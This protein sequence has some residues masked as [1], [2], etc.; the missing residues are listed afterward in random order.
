MWHVDTV[1]TYI[2][3]DYVMYVCMYSICMRKLTFLS[4]VMYK[5]HINRMCEAHVSISFCACM[6]RLVHIQDHIHSQA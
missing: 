2:A 4:R 6:K 5:L 1:G 3:Q